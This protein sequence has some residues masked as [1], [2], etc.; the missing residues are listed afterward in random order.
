MASFSSTSCLVGF[1]LSRA[2]IM[3]AV[4]ISPTGVC[5]GRV[6]CF[7]LWF[8][9][10][11]LILSFPGLNNPYDLAIAMCSEYS[12]N[13]STTTLKHFECVVKFV[14]SCTTVVPNGWITTSFI[15]Q[16]LPFTPSRSYLGMSRP[17]TIFLF[18]IMVLRC[19][20][21]QVSATLLQFCFGHSCH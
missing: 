4:V 14:I 2:G 12:V 17:F 11:A 16:M 18:K 9:R 7:V 3:L 10:Q 5:I 15:V 8:L 6:T 19:T 13:G 1:G 20:Y 21:F